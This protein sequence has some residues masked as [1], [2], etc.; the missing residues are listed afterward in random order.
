VENKSTDYPEL[1]VVVIDTYDELCVLAEKEVCRLSRVKTGQPC[2]SVNAAFGGFGRGQDK[3]VEIIQDA[4]WDLKKVGVAFIIVAHVKR[5]TMDDLTGDTQYSMLTASTTQ[6]YFNAIKTKLDFLGMAYIDRDIVME[7]TGKKDK[8]GSDKLR[9]KVVNE[10]RI[11]NFRDDSYSL[12]SKC[13]FAGIIDRIPF[14]PDEFIKA[15]QDAIQI[16]AN[17]SGKTKEEMLAEQKLKDQAAAEKQ[18]QF[19]ESLRIEK[20]EAENVEKYFNIIKNSFSSADPTLKAAAKKILNDAGF[21]K[22]TDSD[23]PAAVLKEIASLFV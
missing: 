23:I 17:K 10:S 9:G 16:E 3:V 2:D 20:E 15:M 13:R 21:E 6:K 4:L 11:I 14:D 12:D 7:K 18:I 5:S 1:K 22:F 8:D 19:E